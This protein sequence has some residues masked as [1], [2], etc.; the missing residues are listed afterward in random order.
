MPENNF[1]EVPKTIEELLEQNRQKKNEY[2]YKGKDA[3]KITADLKKAEELSKVLQSLENSVGINHPEALK[4]K[5]ELDKLVE[6]LKKKI[7]GY[8]KF[9]VVEKPTE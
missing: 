2:F 7:P 3:E 1:N 4:V 8:G 5:K 6:E 9:P